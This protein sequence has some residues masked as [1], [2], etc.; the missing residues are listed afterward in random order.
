MASVEKFGVF[1]WDNAK[2]G[3]GPKS[4]MRSVR[5]VLRI[6]ILKKKNDLHG[7]SLLN[8]HHLAAPEN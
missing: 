7:F 2:R 1:V 3:K 8:N 5:G 6:Y 4:S